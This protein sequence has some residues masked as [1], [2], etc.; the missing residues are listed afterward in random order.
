MAFDLGKLIKPRVIPAVPERFQVKGKR[1]HCSTG[2]VKHVACVME[3]EFS[4][5]GV[6]LKMVEGGV[7]G[8]ESMYVYG[9]HAAPDVL[10]R[11]GKKPWWANAGTKGSWDELEIDEENMAALTVWVKEKLDLA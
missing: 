6:V 9:S 2:E 4:E 7:T 3:L 10:E 1:T 11:L 8:Y 5:R